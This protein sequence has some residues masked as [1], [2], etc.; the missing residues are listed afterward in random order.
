[1]IANRFDASLSKV[2]RGGWVDPSRHAGGGPRGFTLLEVLVVI[3]IVAVLAAL[4]TPAALD[5]LGMAA[6]LQCQA[7][8]R[9]IAAAYARYMTDSGGVWPPILVNDP[10]RG[11][12]EQIEAETGLVMAPQ[13]PAAGWGQPGPHWS[14]VLWP[15]IR[16]LEVYTCPADPKS[17]L[18]GGEVLPPGSERGVA[19]RDAPPESY[20]LN[21]ILF[22]TADGMRREAGCEW[23]TEGDCEF[24]GL[25]SCTTL[26][27]QRQQFPQWPQVIL[28]FCGAAG[29]TV[30]SQFNVPFR[31]SGLVERWEWHPRQASAPFADEPGRGANYLYADGRVEYHDELP[32]KREWGY[33][34]GRPP[35]PGGLPAAE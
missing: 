12:F 34:I 20:A 23:G 9:T 29:Q 1:M 24:N 30:G 5:A 25:Q 17:G 22:R 3:A 27:E 18:R 10:P 14:I 19:L 7:N 11:P 32:A 21:V 13:R 31:T 15:Y 2:G 16:S 26:G 6:M 35:R 8:L 33:D 28:F 4:L